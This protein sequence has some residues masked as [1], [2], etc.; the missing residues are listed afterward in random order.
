M[1]CSFY[2]QI[3][4]KQATSMPNNMKTLSLGA[5]IKVNDGSGW[6]VGHLYQ[7]KAGEVV[8]IANGCY[9]RWFDPV[10]CDN[11]D[12]ITWEELLSILRMCCRDAKNGIQIK[13]ENRWVSYVNY[14]HAKL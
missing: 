4:V 5:E 9:N 7:V 2:N 10:E 3:L 8:F 13:V 14:F 12:A 6:Y 11:I 1:R